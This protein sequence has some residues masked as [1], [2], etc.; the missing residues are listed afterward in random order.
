MSCNLEL[1]I[2]LGLASVASSCHRDMVDQPHY[3]TYSP[4]SRWSDGTS[5]RPLPE[6]TVAREPAPDD[7][8]D[9][10]G[11]GV[12]TRTELPFALTA[13]GLARGRELYGVYCTPCH[14]ALGDGRGMVVQRG[15]Q[16]PPSYHSDRLR[17]APYG[18]VYQVITQ[19]FGAML[20]P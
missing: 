3:E 1:A 12:G 14:G 20:E 7:A 11:P 18:H 5:A 4:S 10:P 9:L 13:D 8:E 15:F 19:G 6:G 16:Q 2:G 17:Q